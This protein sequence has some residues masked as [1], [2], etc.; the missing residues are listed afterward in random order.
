MADPFAFSCVLL[1][2]LPGSGLVLLLLI[3]LAGT[4]ISAL[5]RSSGLYIPEEIEQIETRYGRRNLA[6]CL[7][8][9]RQLQSSLLVIKYFF[10]I[11]FT[12]L[13]YF[14]LQ[15]YF[16]GSG[17]RVLFPAI[18]M[19]SLLGFLFAFVV[20]RFMVAR[21]SRPL[22]RNSGPIILLAYFLL[23]PFSLL[24]MRIVNYFEARNQESGNVLSMDELSR[25]LDLTQNTTT[26]SDEHRLL[27]GIVTFGTMDITRIMKPKMDIEAF[28]IS[29]PF[30]KLIRDILASGYSR[31]PVYRDNIDHIAGILY[32]KDLLSHLNDAEDFKWQDLLRPCF[33]IPENTKPDDLLREFQNKKTHLAIVVD[34]FGQTAGLVT[35]EDIIEEIVGEINDEFDDDEVAYSKLDE[36]NYIFEG[37]TSM[38]DFL[39]II[40]RS[41][42]SMS[43][44]KSDADT[45]SGFIIEQAGRFPQRNEK[46]TWEYCTFSIESADSRRIKRVKVTIR[47]KTNQ[48]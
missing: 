45:L 21:I 9:S 30:P 7:R 18:V 25:A 1:L 28:D 40:G 31:M 24:F 15:M 37:K 12:F 29:I 19:L 4:F 47:K 39:R 22:V 27:K 14:L 5:E 33:F 6:E 3:L 38:N 10:T 42:E 23:K 43:S 46:V 34:E 16:P 8:N 13:L 2:P 48:E 26:N 44:L 11:S 36:Q 32:I 41:E 35:L 17:Q 20:S